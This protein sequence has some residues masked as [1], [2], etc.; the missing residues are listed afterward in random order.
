MPTKRIKPERKNRTSQ[1]GVA[2]TIYVAPFCKMFD[3]VLFSSVQGI[4]KQTMQAHL[5][6]S[7]IDSLLKSL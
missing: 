7:E 4:M 6:F 2:D 3:R 1:R 5:S